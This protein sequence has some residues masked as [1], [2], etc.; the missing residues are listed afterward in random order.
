MSKK[1]LTARGIAALQ[2][3]KTKRLEIPDAGA[4][5]LYLL[6]QPSGAKSWALRYRFRGKTVKLTLGSVN[7]E[8]AINSRADA[9]PPIGGHL[10]LAEARHLAAAQR[11][12]LDQGADP[13]ERREQAAE[14]QKRE[15]ERAAGNSIKALV[16]EFIKKHMVDKKKRS[17]GQVEW[18]FGK[19]VLPEWGGRDIASITKRDVIKLVDGI[20]D[21]GTPT[22]ANRVFA[23]V[24]KLF[25]WAKG[26]DFIEVSPVDGIEPPAEERSRDRV[27]TDDEI[28]IFW[29]A[30]E[31]AGQPFGKLFQLLLLTAQRRDEVA[32]ALWSE[33]EIDQAK[34]DEALWVIPAARAKNGKEHAV[35]LSRAAVDLLASVKP[36]KSKSGFIFTTSGTAPVSGF[37]R[38]KQALDKRMKALLP[39]GVALPDWT[40]HD[41]RRTAATGMAALAIPIHVTE[42]VLNHK[43]GT[44]KGV[45]AIYNRH[46]YLEEKRQALNAWARRVE[47]IVSGRKEHNVID[48]ATARA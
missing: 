37:S 3:D 15:V 12:L 4:R 27:L 9:T 30:C 16:A 13:V 47:T 21:A 23:A 36:I 25:N 17:A 44:I 42:A 28:R 46:A 29:K 7:T 18:I 2:P 14:E 38:A 19:Y 31:S 43:S 5:G 40:L 41:L 1:L 34:P 26:K 6:V 33:M 32:C 22:M 11:S 35:P 24:R 8:E 39:E 10:T 45:A 20:V 48:L